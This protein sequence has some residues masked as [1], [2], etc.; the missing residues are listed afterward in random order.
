MVWRVPHHLHRLHRV[1]VGEGSK[2]PSRGYERCMTTQ[3]PDRELPLPARLAVGLEQDERLDAVVEAAGRVTSPLGQPGAR[4]LLGG[5]WMGHAL[6]PSLTDLPL[7]LWTAA[8]VLDV[9]GGPP[10]RPAAQRLVGLGVLSALPTAATGWTEWHR[11]ER[12][13]Q[14]VGVVHAALNVTAIGAYAGSWRAR[15]RGR[16]GLGATL[17]VAGAV[18]AAT[19][20][21]LGG[22]LTSVRKVSSRHP[23]FDAAPGADRADRADRAARVAGESRT[24]ASP[25]RETITGHD[26]L[27][28][29]NAQHA[30][31]S[32]LVNA[33]SF[34]DPADRTATLHRFLSYLAGHEAVEE[35]LLH[36][37]GAETG[38]PGVGTQRM[39]EEEGVG[40]QIG[41]LEK[42]GVD[43]P[44][45]RTQF[46]LIEEAV[47]QHATAEENVELPQVVQLL[48]DEEAS[49]VVRAFR[50]QEAGVSKRTGT[51]AE[52]LTVARADVRRLA[53]T[54]A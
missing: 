7:G 52:M 14:R 54:T 13:V 50:S 49:I 12:P 47:T 42:L 23:G 9:L 18:A 19:A 35:E 25:S 53:S 51:F 21:Y 40:E 17:A 29:V 4:R 24:P 26:V 45:F 27:E 38:E 11:A 34:A 33:V 44:L 31:L 3:H 36:P 39:T 32:R 22:H 41:Q 37:R 20:G 16:H 46:G 2:V 10:A 6:H 30:E 48:S 1:N 5:D 15:R 43:S 8:S 28:V